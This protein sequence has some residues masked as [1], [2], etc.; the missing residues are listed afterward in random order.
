MRRYFRRRQALTPMSCESLE[1]R[2]LFSTY[3]VGASAPYHTIQAAV[4]AVR[5]LN[6][7]K[8]AS[9]SSTIEVDPG[10]YV[11]QVYIPAVYRNLQP[12]MNLTI[13]SLPTTS[14]G[15]TTYPKASSTIIQSP[16]PLHPFVSSK[17]VSYGAIIWDAGATNLS[18]LGFTI[19]GPGGNVPATA[20]GYT[21]VT[22]SPATAPTGA[23]PEFG[24]G[25]AHLDFG[26]LVTGGTAT[27]EF[28][29]ITKIQDNPATT[30]DH[31]D[32]IEVRDPSSGQTASANI[33][34]NTIDDYQKAG[35]SIDT[36]GNGTITGNTVTGN[37]A[38]AKVG[39]N[40]IQ[41]GNGG[42]A[43]VESNTVSDN[44]GH[45]SLYSASGILLIDAGATTVQSNTVSGNDEN[46]V[47]D[48]ATGAY[49]AYNTV[50]N[51][52]Y[53]GIDVF[54][55][56]TGAYVGHNSSKNN[57]LDGIYVVS[58]AAGNTFEYNTSTGNGYYDEEDDSTGTKTA[59][60]ANTW[61]HDTFDTASPSGLQ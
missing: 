22:Q 20:P 60:T 44:E 15:H 37:G 9:V 30:Y 56:T 14:G 8:P 32:A 18:I 40:G 58:G 6:P 51:A 52:A 11:G 10:T 47:I 28:N 35:I 38:S 45:S 33:A 21:A 50:S 29:H 55:Q 48:N 49:V 25:D 57:G 1:S 41:V 3:V 24:S 26:I 12:L 17:D 54:D 2:T 19:E 43:V 34:N 7:S 16:V 53:D 4:D 42:K 5:A 46:I 36:G 13:K 31:G 27:I 61:R 59:G 23:G 39:Q